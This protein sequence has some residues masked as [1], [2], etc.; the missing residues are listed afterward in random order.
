MKLTK[1]EPGKSNP[2]PPF[3]LIAFS[4]LV[5]ISLTMTGCSKTVTSPIGP[6]SPS[7]TLVSFEN[8]IQPI[9]NS[10]CAV[11]GC[12]AGP[13]PQDGMSLAAGT[14]YSQ[15]VNVQC[16]DVPGYLLIKPY[17]PD[18]SFLYLKITGNS[19]AGIR[20]PYQRQPLSD[21]MTAT[22]ARWIS[23]GARNN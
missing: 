14:S 7:D 19:A 18:S 5:L 3:E 17:Y 12:H 20:M 8:D 23:Q 15:I 11:S 1:R 13:Q 6:G 4:I 16:I 9:F 10:Y 22:I 2:G 21:T